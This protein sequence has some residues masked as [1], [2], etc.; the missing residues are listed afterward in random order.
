MT[1]DE[2]PR[3]LIEEY[4]DELRRGLRALP[5]EAEVILAEAGIPVPQGGE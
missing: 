5:G 4:L 3:D 1:R 2:A